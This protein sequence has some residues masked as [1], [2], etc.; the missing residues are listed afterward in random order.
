MKIKKIFAVSISFLLIFAFL[1]TMVNN[2]SRHPD[3][4]SESEHIARVSKRL[5]RKYFDET[6]EVPLFSVSPLYTENDK[7]RYFVVEFE[8]SGFL[9]VYIHRVFFFSSHQRM[10]LLDSKVTKDRSW[11]DLNGVEHV[12]SHYKVANVIDDK[13]YFLQTN[14]PAFFIPAIKNSNK[15]LN[16]ITME[17]LSHDYQDLNLEQNAYNIGFIPKTYFDL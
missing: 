9:Y 14:N 10:Y 8:P 12:I 6:G 3:S 7:L 2:E 13:R 5:E 15:Y 4:F 11:T 1:L 16:L 17:F